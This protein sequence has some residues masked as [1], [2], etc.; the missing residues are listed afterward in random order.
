M[1]M[2][3][4]VRRSALFAALLAT[5]FAAGCGG[6]EKT[7]ANKNVTIG[8][9]S[10]WGSLDPYANAG[11]YSDIIADQIFDRLWTVKT[12]GT[13]KPRLAKSY[14]VAKDHSEMIVH[15]DPRAKFT[16][17]KPVTAD[18][19]VFSAA[20]NTDP[21]FRSA[22]R[23]DFRYVAGTTAGGVAED[24]SKLGVEKIDEHTVRI[25]FK[26][27]MDEL[28]ILC[29]LNRY[30][31][32]VP[33]HIFGDKSAEELNKNE[34]W[35][36]NLIGSGPFK[37]KDAIDGERV[38]FVRNDD[39]FLG[40]ADIEKLTVR[41]VPGSQ[42]LSGLKAGEIDITAGSSIGN[43]PIAD[44][45]DA[46]SDESIA[47]VSEPEYGYQAMI[48]N[49]QSPKLSNKY[50]RQ[51]LSA[52]I[53]R[54]AIVENLLE[55]EAQVL[56]VPFSGR[57]PFVDEAGFENA[58]IYDPVRAK[59]LLDKGGFDY[60]ETLD[61]I[62]PTGNETR[63]QSTVLIQQDLEAIGVHSKI[64]QYDFSTLMEKMRNGDFDLG[65]CG[66]AGGVDPSVAVSWL[67]SASPN[68]F[69][70]ASDAR[71]SD[72]FALAGKEVDRAKKKAAYTAVWNLILDEA[73][74]AY[75]Y[76]G[77]SLIAY[78]KTRLSQIAPSYFGQVNWDVV[79]WKVK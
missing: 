75:L 8:I 63:M 79:S 49:L 12:D 31:Y 32:I 76:S 37:Y 65:M 19:V 27:P 40:K 23:N 57:H 60:S 36:A 34:T 21:A 25:R 51:G 59:E 33:K 66:S 15:L 62:V 48:F 42:L 11:N 18:D 10:A 70:N 16:D 5:A 28:A 41:V 13:V 38:E 7:G 44:W 77:N 22:K 46:E 68:N 3:K 67:N 17:G 26:E 64:T 20:L 29:N 61:L 47:T 45:K 4:W 72:A 78:N 53:D 6:A 74:I 30:L 69:S 50:I 2:K 73:P 39:Y 54:K 71:F 9:V 14:E 1:K 55:N 43:L 35:R 24:A 58:P 52:A 56:Y